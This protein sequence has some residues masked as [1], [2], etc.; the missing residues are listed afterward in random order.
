MQLY[1]YCILENHLHLIAS[2]EHLPKKSATFKSFTA[3]SVIDLLEAR[4]AEQ[5]FKPTYVP[6]RRV[7]RRTEEFQLWQEGSHPSKSATKL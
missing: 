2:S 5:F 1:G 3:R 4:G 7:T 6:I